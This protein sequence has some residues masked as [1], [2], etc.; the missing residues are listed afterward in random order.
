MPAR[1]VLIV[2][3]AKPSLPREKPQNGANQLKEKPPDANWGP[4]KE[5]SNFMS[6]NI[7]PVA[8]F[9]VPVDAVPDLETKKSGTGPAP[10]WVR[11]AD[12][13]R[14]YPG[15]FLPVT[16]DGLKPDRLRSVPGDIKRGKLG[17]FKTGNWDAC[18]RGN[19]LYVSYQGETAAT[20]L[21]IAN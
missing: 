2:F 17:A 5:R 13:C 14:K 1:L 18:Y 4:V 6:K 3:V 9:G 11:V 7:T 15:K 16:I 8:T 21:K 12:E 10:Y 19:Q 20:P